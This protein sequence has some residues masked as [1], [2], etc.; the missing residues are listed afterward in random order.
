MFAAVR[1][2]SSTFRSKAHK[3]TAVQS[4]NPAVGLRIGYHLV[5]IKLRA[6][7]PTNFRVSGDTMNV[8]KSTVA[9]FAIEDTR[10]QAAPWYSDETVTPE[11]RGIPSSL[12]RLSPFAR[13]RIS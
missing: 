7:E 3:A 11:I 8:P 9:A 4:Q 10:A 5:H 12:L 6:P 13:L 1:T 2:S